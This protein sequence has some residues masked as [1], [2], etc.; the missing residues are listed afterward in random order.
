MGGEKIHRGVRQCSHCP[1]LGSPH[2]GCKS[3]DS[4]NFV[5]SRELERRQ[6]ATSKPVKVN[7]EAQKVSE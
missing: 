3:I 6:Q 2:I 1:E 4:A 7:S 5:S